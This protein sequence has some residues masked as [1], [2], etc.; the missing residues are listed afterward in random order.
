MSDPT[1]TGPTHD[2][3]A[4]LVVGETGNAL[5][6]MTREFQRYA[7]NPHQ[8]P[9]LAATMHFYGTKLAEHAREMAEGLA[10]YAAAHPMLEPDPEG[11]PVQLLP[12]GEHSAFWEDSDGTVQSYGAEVTAKYGRPELTDQVI[13]LEHV[14]RDM[15][16]GGLGDN[17]VIVFQHFTG[18]LVAD[19]PNA[20]RVLIGGLDIDEHQDAMERVFEH[21]GVVPVQPRYWPPVQGVPEKSFLN[22][23]AGVYDAFGRPLDGPT[24]DELAARAGRGMV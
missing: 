19:R 5:Q 10:Q 14:L 1:T 7:S 18:S 24:E 21:F 17:P 20:A 2:E 15:G 9:H 22:L 16:L 8:W 11:V 12:P 4:Y 23:Q 3:L 13:S 6:A